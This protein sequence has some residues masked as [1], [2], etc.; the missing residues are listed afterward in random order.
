[1]SKPNRHLLCGGG[2][3][4]SEPT[5][6][7]HWGCSHMPLRRLL[8]C[9]LSPAHSHSSLPPPAPVGNYQQLLLGRHTKPHPTQ[10]SWTGSSTLRGQGCCRERGPRLLSRQLAWEEGEGECCRRKE[11]GLC[12][13]AAALVR[14][15][16]HH[17][18]GAGAEAQSQDLSTCSLH[19]QAT[20]H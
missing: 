3:W 15:K 16:V 11:S 8:E 19:S 17:R 10:P 6:M 4:K 5:C 14:Q 12:V 13:P 18:D 7:G 9:F 2:W 20:A 1:M